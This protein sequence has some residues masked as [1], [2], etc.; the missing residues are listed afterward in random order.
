MIS[1]NLSY[2]MSRVQ[3]RCVVRDG[4]DTSFPSWTSQL[5]FV[6]NRSTFPKLAEPTAR[7]RIAESTLNTKLHNTR[8]ERSAFM[9]IR[10][11]RNAGLAMELMME[12]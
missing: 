2:S 1:E 3:S 7:G 12:T 9:S 10:S 8:L 5:T 11:N 6:A 4:G